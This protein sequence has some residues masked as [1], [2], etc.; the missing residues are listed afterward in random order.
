[1]DRLSDQM[2]RN[3]Y[4]LTIVASVMLPL[5]FVTGLLGVN[6][7][8]MPGTKDAPWA[9]TTVCVAMVMLVVIEIWFRRRRRW[10]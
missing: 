4:L 3:I 2:N 10:F 8:G 5:G 1:M 7:D 9:F 6:V